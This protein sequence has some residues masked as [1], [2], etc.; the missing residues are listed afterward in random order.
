MG[1]EG[2][3]Q[4]DDDDMGKMGIPPCMFEESLVPRKEL[5]EA[6]AQGYLKSVE[7]LLDNFDFPGGINVRDASGSTPFLRAA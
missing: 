1:E 6:C 5:F 7:F 3:A 4:H 2:A